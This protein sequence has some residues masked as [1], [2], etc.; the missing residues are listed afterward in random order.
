MA[1]L[2]LAATI[3][4]LVQLSFQAALKL[5]NIARKLRHAPQNLRRNY[6]STDGFYMLHALKSALKVE[7]VD[8]LHSDKDRDYNEDLL[9]RCNKQASSCYSLLLRVMPQG[10]RVRVGFRKRFLFIMKEEDFPERLNNLDDLRSDLNSRST[11]QIFLFNCC[12]G[13]PS[14]TKA[15]DRQLLRRRRTRRGKRKGEEG[16]ESEAWEESS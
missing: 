13:S 16:E 10:G 5:K 11:R 12:R 7:S 9:Q 1:V 2:A 15:V 8:L 4:P 14:L 6:R 3:V